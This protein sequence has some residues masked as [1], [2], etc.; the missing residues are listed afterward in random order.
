MISREKFIDAVEK[1]LAEINN[2]KPLSN[3]SVC[4]EKAL[5]FILDSLCKGNFK[6]IISIKI[7]NY[8]LYTPRVD[9]LEVPIESDYKW[10]D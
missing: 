1:R 10:L 3:K 7:D 8:D 6:G 2:N 9:Q 4:A 5:L